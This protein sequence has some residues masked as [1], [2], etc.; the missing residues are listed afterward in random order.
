MLWHLVEEP[1]LTKNGRGRWGRDVARRKRE[2]GDPE[3]EGF[4]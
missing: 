1:G 4:E 2:Q 3:D